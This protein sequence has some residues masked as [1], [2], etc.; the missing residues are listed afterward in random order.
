MALFHSLPIVVSIVHSR[1]PSCPLGCPPNMA[2]L[3]RPRDMNRKKVREVVNRW[4]FPTESGSYMGGLEKRPVL[5]KSEGTVVTDTDGKE[6][7][8]FQS[9]QMGAALGHQ[10]PRIVA[11]I[12]KT[13]KSLMHSTNTMLHVPRLKLHETLGKL[14]PKPLEK[15][16]FLVSGSDSIEGSVDLARKA[17]GGLDIIGLHAGLHGST[18]YVTRSLSFNW[19]RWKHSAVAP[20]TNSVLTPYCYR[21]PVGQNHKKKCGF[22]CLR[23]SMELADANFTAKPAGFIAEPILSAGGVIVPPEGYYKA[24]RKACDKRGMMLIFDEAQTGLGKTG[25]LFGFQHEKGVKPDIIAISKHFGGGL[26]IS[27]VCSTAEVAQKAVDNGYFATRSHATDPVL[28]AAGEESLNIVVDEDM[29]GKAAK[30][31]K[32]IKG[33]FRKMAREFELVGDI[34]GRGVLLGIELVKDRRTKK[35]ANEETQKIFDY[36]MDKGLIFQIRGVR[37]MKNV[38]RLVPPMTTPKEQV[39]RAMSIM[40][41]AFKSVAKGKRRRKPARAGAR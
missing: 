34:R 9:G 3:G 35:P 14:L 30:I 17:T 2:K 18:S 31:E 5:A 12:E 36:C 29:P 7:L 27:A 15:S 10:H 13:M 38:I 41:D 21:C 40:Y 24:V 4:M 11:V 33:A 22:E 20:G 37:D 25:K 28:C 6:Y 1:I 19:S 23:I 32:K 39:D 16:L 8:D 26:P